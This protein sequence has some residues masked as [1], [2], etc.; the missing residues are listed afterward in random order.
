MGEGIPESTVFQA[1]GQVDYFRDGLNGETGFHISERKVL[2]LTVKHIYSKSTGIC[3]GQLRDIIGAFA[4]MG[5]VETVFIGLKKDLLYI[6]QSDV[7]QPSSFISIIKHC[8]VSPSII[9]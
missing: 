8:A 3:F 4:F 6:F 9:N 7:F 5:Y 1:D 2:S